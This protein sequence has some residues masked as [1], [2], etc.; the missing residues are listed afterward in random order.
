MPQNTAR[1]WKYIRYS[2]TTPS[3]MAL[4]ALESHRERRAVADENRSW[5]CFSVLKQVMRDSTN[6]AKVQ[7]LFLQAR[8]T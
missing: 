8:V 4:G 3:L 2:E 5:V 1:L 7:N 6:S